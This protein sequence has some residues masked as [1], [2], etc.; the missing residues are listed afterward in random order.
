MYGEFLVDGFQLEKSDMKN[1]YNLLENSNFMYTT[2]N[3]PN[4][5]TVSNFET[6]DYVR[7]NADRVELDYTDG[8]SQSR[9]VVK[10]SGV[11]Q[12]DVRYEYDENADYLADK[13]WLD[14]MGNGMIQYGYDNFQRLIERS[15]TLSNVN[16]NTKIRTTISYEAATDDKANPISH[17]KN[18]KMNGSVVSGTYTSLEYSYDADGNIT[19]VKEGDETIASYAYDALGQLVFEGTENGNFMY[20]YNA[21]GNLTAKVEIVGFEQHLL[22]YVG[23]IPIYLPIPILEVVNGYEYSATGWKDKLINYNGKAITYDAIGNPLTYDGYTYTWQKGRQLQKIVGNG[24]S[25][26]FTYNQDGLRTKKING[27]TTTEYTWLGD[28]LMVQNT[29][30]D[31][32]NFVYDENGNPIGLQR[33][34][35]N[36]YYLYNA[37]GDVIAICDGAGVLVAQYSYDAWGNVL[38]VQDANGANITSGTHIA[39]VNPLRYRGYYYDVETKLY[40]LQ[41]RYYSPEWGRF[42]NADAYCDTDTGILGTNMFLYGNNNP[43]MNTD[44]TGYNSRVITS[45]SNAKN[46]ITIADEICQKSTVIKIT[47]TNYRVLVTAP[48][49]KPYYKTVKGYK[50]TDSLCW[51]AVKDYGFIRI[52]LQYTDPDTIPV[53]LRWRAEAFVYIRTVAEWKAYIVR[54]HGNVVLKVD[55]KLEKIF[56]EY[57]MTAIGEILASEAAG[58]KLNAVGMGYD[59]LVWAAEKL[60]NR[61]DAEDKYIL[62]HINGKKPATLVMLLHRADNYKLCA[63]KNRTGKIV[64]YKWAFSYTTYAHKQ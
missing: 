28:Q 18:E 52:R 49:Y 26:A 38:S 43:V 37:Q 25:Y 63:Q 16:P 33:N 24:K 57:G 29:G 13:V 11:V 32:L 59:V 55:S 2:S 39:N 23:S 20:I 31:V 1:P 45:T 34:S 51:Y 4:N 40:Y 5:W 62:K 10:K 12:S 44:Y 50:L 53:A 8:G 14:S 36:Y 9:V 7:Y 48:P 17:W 64:S 21:G 22:G 35:V 60:S 6:G 56:S 30:G 47:K 61:R 46:L 15:H 27:T 58:A 54:K 3:R 41:S 19:S 42:L